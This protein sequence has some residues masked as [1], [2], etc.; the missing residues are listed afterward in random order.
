MTEYTYSIDREQ[1]KIW[2]SYVAR[3]TGSDPQYIL[4]RYFEKVIFR[5]GF[6]GYSCSTDLEN[7]LY[8]V[9][10]KR[11]DIQSGELTSRLR[12]W[13]IVVDDDI[14]EY[15]FEEMNWQYALFTVYNIKHNYG[16]GE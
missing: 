12:W 15:E 3:I 5:R 2:R 10:I 8:E 14:Y 11:Y 16:L 6:H 4:R 13:I 9:C 7:G 1:G